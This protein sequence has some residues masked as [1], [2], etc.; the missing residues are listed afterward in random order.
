[1]SLILRRRPLDGAVSIP[2]GKEILPCTPDKLPWTQTTHQV[3]TN[4]K[5]LYSSGDPHPLPLGGR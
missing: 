4:R 1:M 3:A 2:V 5:K